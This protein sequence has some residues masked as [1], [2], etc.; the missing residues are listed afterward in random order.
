MKIIDIY[1]IDVVKNL[2]LYV[3]NT[4]SI[5]RERY[6]YMSRYTYRTRANITRGF[7]TYYPLFEVH[8]CTVTFGLMYG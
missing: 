4:V 1:I 5:D 6:L 7:Y 2:G 8:L 3:P